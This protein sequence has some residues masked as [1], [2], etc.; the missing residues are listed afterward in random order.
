MAHE[1]CILHKIL[2]TSKSPST[3]HTF[4]PISQI[5]SKLGVA[6]NNWIWKDLDPILHTLPIMVRKKSLLIGINYT[7]SRNELNGCHQDVQNVAE[8]LSYRGY[9]DSPQ[10]QVILRDDVSGPYYPSGANI[11]V[12]GQE[13]IHLHNVPCSIQIDSIPGSDRL[14]RLRTWYM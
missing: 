13:M 12:S 5:E 1:P 10:S 3:P 4:V 14:A 2:P 9:S 8:F 11:L 6:I 7:G